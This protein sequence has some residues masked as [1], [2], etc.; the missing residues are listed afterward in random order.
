MSVPRVDRI[1][2]S[3]QRAIQQVLTRGLNDPRMDSSMVT[4]TEV[5]LAQDGRDATVHV[6]VMPGKHGPR[7]L[8]AIKHASGHIR[9]EAG[10]LIRMRALP[11]LHFV[12]DER[13]KRQASVIAAL[14]QIPDLA[15]DLAPDL[16]PELAPDL[17]PDPAA[18]PSVDAA[19]TD[20]S[21]PLRDR[22]PAK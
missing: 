16:S 6:S 21:A 1:S 12:L 10:E 18:D 20:P 17:A 7:C 2:S 9:R 8:G 22:G 15:P 4:I 13:L 3:L 19:P 5:D 14:G 11:Q